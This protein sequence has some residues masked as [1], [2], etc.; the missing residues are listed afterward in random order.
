M[1][2]SD[3]LSLHAQIEANLASASPDL[4]RAMV[5]TF[6]DA[7]MASTCRPHLPSHRVRAP[8]TTSARQTPLH[9][10]NATA[11]GIWRSQTPRPGAGC[12]ARQEPGRCRG[13]SPIAAPVFRLRLNARSH[14]SRPTTGHHDFG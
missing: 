6:A 12:T 8:G 7:L 9:R 4:L 10:S 14:G 1:T 3:S 5:K 2:A 11:A 13:R